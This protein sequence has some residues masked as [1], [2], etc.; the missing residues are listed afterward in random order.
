MNRRGAA[1]ERFAERRRQEDEAPRL[2]DVVPTLTACRVVFEERREGVTGSDLSHTRRI[3]VEH[4]PARL[5]V[6]CG[7]SDCRDGGH[8]ISA[9]LVRG[10]RSGQAEIHGE[11]RCFGHVRA[12]DCQRVLAFTAYAEYGGAR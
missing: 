10:L 2:R 5:V 8:D 3:V 4:A 9:E 12:A 7:D 6:P 1:A 11:D